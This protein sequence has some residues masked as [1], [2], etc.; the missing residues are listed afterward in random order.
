M[1]EK[2]DKN[3][4]LEVLADHGAEGVIARKILRQQPKP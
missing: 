4:R 3:G 1:A 2:H